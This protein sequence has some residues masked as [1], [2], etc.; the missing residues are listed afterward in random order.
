MG[1]RALPSKPYT[2][3]VFTP[4]EWACWLIDQSGAFHCWQDGG[5]VFDPTCGN[6]AFLEAFIHLAIDAGHFE[7]SSLNRLYGN[8]IVEDDRDAFRRRIR[9]EYS[10]DFPESHFTT[11][12]FLLETVEGRFDC[13]VGNPPWANFADLSESAK[14]PVKKA[15]EKYGLVKNRRDVLLG[16]SRAD[17]AALVVQKALSEN[18]SN[19]GLAAFWLPKSIFFNEGANRNFRQFSCDG[20]DYACETLFLFDS[21]RKA[22]FPAVKTLYC[23]AVFRKNTSQEVPVP[24]KRYV[25]PNRWEHTFVAPPLNDPLGGWQE[26]SDGTSILEF[27]RPRLAAFQKPRQ[28]VNTCGATDLF[29][30]DSFRQLDFDKVEVSNKRGHT[31]VAPSHL[32]FPLATRQ[33]FDGLDLGPMKWVFLPYDANTGDPLTACALE[34][35][36]SV[37]T[38]LSAHESLL[39]QRKGVMIQ[40][41]ISKGFFWSLFGVGRYTFA[42]WKVMWEAYGKK[43][44]RA[45]KVSGEWQA[46]QAM[47]AYIPCWSDTDADKVLRLLSLMNV[48][49]Q[50]LRHGMEGTTNWAQPG[51][52]ARM[53]ELVNEK[54]EA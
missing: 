33:L 30:F 31:L 34:S 47:H 43:E 1:T 8:E 26:S 39:R 6:G 21:Q 44:F 3:R 19:D 22:V 32:V 52:I 29:V 50:L 23:A 25:A 10:L 35:M 4:L 18:L 13:V 38:Y 24:A 20:Q 41:Q 2:G 54:A 7:V 5:T 12:D 51:R 49:D 27:E 17:V 16:A 14:E 40:S 28:G 45:V 37:W 53:F 15:F 42:P 48:Q 36:P 9:A 11:T 46:N